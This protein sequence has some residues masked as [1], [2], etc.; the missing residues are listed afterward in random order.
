MGPGSLGNLAKARELLQGT[1]QHQGLVHTTKAWL[2][3][4]SQHRQEEAGPDLTPT[5]EVSDVLI[6]RQLHYSHI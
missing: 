4:R 1:R 6:L 5:Q 3:W 2:S